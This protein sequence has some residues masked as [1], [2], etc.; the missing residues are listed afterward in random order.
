M[1]A[2]EILQ[3]AIS[4]AREC[5]DLCHNRRTGSTHNIDLANIVQHYERQMTFAYIEI[6]KGNSK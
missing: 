3:N 6:E 2:Q 5:I 4:H 1:T